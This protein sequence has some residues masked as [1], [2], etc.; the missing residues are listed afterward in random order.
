MSG[1]VVFITGGARSGK[2]GLAL[3]SASAMAG[4]KGFIATATAVDEEMT[5]RIA[6]HRADRSGVWETIEEPLGLAQALEG[7]AGA[8][9]VIVIDCLT[10]WL[11]NVIWS[12]LAVEDEVEKLL[13]ACEKVRDSRK[14]SLYIVSNEVGMGIVP[15]SGLARKFRDLA[16]RLNQKI[17]AASDEAYLVAAGIPLRLKGK[18]A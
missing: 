18:G 11:S 9:D 6:R 12:G 17:A 2:S 7:A 14:V 16:G 3:A 15:E 1:K 8:F 5:A 13:S 10:V 4:R